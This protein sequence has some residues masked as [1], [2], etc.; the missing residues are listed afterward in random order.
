M[1]TGMAPVTICPEVGLV[2]ATAGATRSLLTVKLTPAEVVLLPAASRAVAATVWVP[3]ERA[4][5]SSETVYGAA[6]SSAP[7]SAPSSRS[8]TP[9]TPTLSL[10]AAVTLMVPETVWPAVGLLMETV[11]AVWSLLMV[12]LTVLEVLLLP[13]ASR[14]TA[15]TVWAP[16]ESGH[17]SSE[18]V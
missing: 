14:A 7:R 8:R 15:A 17:V 9:A 6:V 12:K 1:V 18:A 3:F 10:A 16:L 4:L 13:A 2:M 5:V 11:G